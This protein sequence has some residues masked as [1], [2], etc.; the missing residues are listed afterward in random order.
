MGLPIKGMYFSGH[1]EQHSP[2][3]ISLVTNS[4]AKL[5]CFW[6]RRRKEWICS[7]RSITI[8]AIVKVWTCQGSLIWHQHEVTRTNQ[9]SRIIYIKEKTVHQHAQSTTFG[10]LVEANLF[11][12]TGS[13]HIHFFFFFSSKLLTTTSN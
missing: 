9:G 11:R 6:L 12:L 4:W 8:C 13:F 5:S 7:E 2:R 3:F 1:I 10:L